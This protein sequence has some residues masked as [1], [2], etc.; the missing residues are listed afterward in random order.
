MIAYRWESVG[1][2]LAGIGLI[3]FGVVGFDSL[4]L[5]DDCCIALSKGFAF[6]G[7]SAGDIA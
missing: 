1:F 5:D 6:S 7:N 4:D 2:Y 3:L